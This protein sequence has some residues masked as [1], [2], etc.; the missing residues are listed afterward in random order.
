MQKGTNENI[1]YDLES[2]PL[3]IKQKGD[4]TV[5]LFFKDAMDAVAGNIFLIFGQKK[6]K[7]DKCKDLL[8]YKYPIPE[9]PNDWT[10][11]ICRIEKP[12]NQ[13][14]SQKLPF[15]AMGY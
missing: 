4:S 2:F 10:T 12:K 8:V 15:T 7:I 14:H 5:K 1:E 9:L 13:S 6:V 3:M 11:K